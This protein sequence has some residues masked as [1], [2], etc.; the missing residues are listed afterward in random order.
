MP[1]IKLARWRKKLATEPDHLN[2][3]QRV[4]AVEGGS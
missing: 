4:L 3:I 2:L 1:E